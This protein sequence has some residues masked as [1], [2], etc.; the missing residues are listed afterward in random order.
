MAKRNAKA[1]PQPK[2]MVHVRSKRY[3]DHERNP[4]GTF[5]PA[6]LNEAMEQSKSRLLKV[7][8]T[9]SLIYSSLRNEHSDGSLWTRL[10]SALRLQLKE[11]NYNDV[12]CLLELE[13]HAVHTLNNLLR[14]SWDLTTY[15]IVKRQLPITLI[16]D[17]APRWKTRNL[18]HFQ[19][20]L[21]V[22]FPDLQRAQIHK[23]IVYS[24]AF[25]LLDY[26]DEISF[27]VPVPP[28]ASAYA[29]FLKITGWAN[30]KPCRELQSTGMRCVATAIIEGRQKK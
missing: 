19:A 4:R 18:H 14:Y 30:G 20:S 25:G 5:K 29:V 1:T 26:P 3:G 7:N 16:L 10:L 21:H 23:E 2:P 12:N 24:P 9:A 6:V 28:R 15:D 22:I 8:E 27:V 13:C 11:K 17:K